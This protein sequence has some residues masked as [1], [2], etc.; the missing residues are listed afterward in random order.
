MTDFKIEINNGT[1]TGTIRPD[2]GFSYEHNLNDLNEA[3]IKIY[4][5]G[6]IKRGLVTEGATIRISRNGTLEFKGYIDFVDYLDGGGLSIH[7][8]GWEVWLK[9]EKGTYANSPWTSTASATIFS[10]VVGD[11]TKFTVGTADAGASIDFRAAISDNIWEVINGIKDKTGQDININY[12][13]TTSDTVDILDHKGSA[14][15][16]ATLNDGKEITNVR[17]SKAAPIGN[18]V[19]VYGKGDGTNQ[20]KSDPTT[21]GIDATS[22]AAYGQITRYVI[23]KRIV[24]VAEANALADIEVAV[25]IGRAHV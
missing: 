2:V 5:T 14:T 3:E 20:I 8:S 18:Y 25:K 6:A 24:S 1:D 17:A 4:G 15:S 13:A 16:V 23:D 21:Y 19:V 10:A 7:A 9:K 22:I 11:S 12:S